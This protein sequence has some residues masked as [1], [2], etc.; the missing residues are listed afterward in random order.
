MYLHR[1]KIENF[2]IFGSR[3]ENGH[4]VID[5]QPGLNLLVGENDS[6][7]TCVIDAIRLL[8]GTVTQDYFTV[9]ES[10]FHVSVAQEKPAPELTILGE[11][12][13]LNSMEAGALLEYLS[14]EGDMAENE[15]Y[16]R[17]WLKAERNDGKEISPRRRRVTYEVR[18]GSD[19]EGKRVE[20][21]AKDFLRATYLKPLRDAVSE[22]SA[23]KGSRLSQVLR[24]YPGIKDQEKDDWD[25]NDMDSKPKTLVG[26]MR[27]AENDLRKVDVIEN[28]TKDVNEKYLEHFSLGEVPLRGDINIRAYGLRQILERM[29][30]NLDDIAEGATRG[31][32][33]HNLLFIA[34]ELLA[35]TPSNDWDPEFPLLLIEEP[36]AH[37]EPQRQLRLIEFL[38][39]H[40][41]RKPTSPQNQMQIVLT[42]HSPNLA[43]RIG[44]KGL[45]V[46]HKGRAF[47][48]GPQ[49]TR[50]NQSDYEFLER[51][52]DV[53][54][55]NMFFARGVLIVEGD[56]EA[57]LLPTLA[58]KIGRSLTK[59]GVS[60]VKVGHVGLFRYSRVFQQKSNSQMSVRV[61]CL[62]DRD[63]PPVE[64]K[65]LLPAE[66]KTEN[67]WPKD[68]ID[69]RINSRKTNDGGPVI[70][71]VSP[72]WTFEFDLALT[73]L[74][75]Y[76][77]V[78]ISLAKSAN[79][80]HA[81][82]P[83]N[84]KAKEIIQEANAKY[85]QWHDER[86]SAKEI[87]CLIYEPLL[88]MQASKAETAQCLASLL[89]RRH[90]A[91]NW[92]EAHWRRALPGYLVRAIDHAT[93]ATN[94]SGAEDEEGGS[95]DAT[96]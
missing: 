96:S 23:R 75:P 43:S 70:T 59:H 18:A 45:I 54:K 11:F 13:G 72:C 95:L 81:S 4:G 56:A 53:T 57:L 3:Q 41:K 5:L 31:L 12:R 71:E 46:M 93:G 10:D 28:A 37:L 42:S 64:A 25:P 83:I 39:D 80:T 34:T 32:G 7:K 1:L 52:L 65:P 22:M 21:A 40:S 67:E 62:A 30:L 26:I 86:K 17:M 58:E 15:F 6:G 69:S 2:R 90:C 60:I 9:Q 92:D 66:R 87:A 74:A 33:I 14:V 88:K 82:F 84:N 38:R 44:V 51:F 36:E 49:F 76:L 91:P 50:L 29:E 68:K 24:A 35:L 47:P 19:E 79:P 55:S 16:L 94:T 89:E 63:I 77:H 61:A 8:V 48:M 78:A 20:G 73:D 27:K 85:K